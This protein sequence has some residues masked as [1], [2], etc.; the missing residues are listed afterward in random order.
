MMRWALAASLALSTALPAGA[1]PAPQ[2]GVAWLQR[3]ASAAREVNYQGTFVYQHGDHVETSRIIHL[4]DATGE[5]EKLEALD[6][7]PREIIRSNDTVQCYLPAD[8]TLKVDRRKPRQS[9]PALL[10]EQLQSLQ[11]FYRIR[12]A[13]TERIAG[14]ET[15]V[16]ALE[17][18]DGMRY[19]HKLWIE[20]DH[21]LLLK[22]AM[23]DDKQRVVEQIAFTQVEIGQPIDRALLKPRFEARVAEWSR[24]EGGEASPGSAAGD[25]SGWQVKEQPP[26][27]RKILETRRN[28]PGKPNPVTH[29]MLSDGMA[30]VSVFIEPIGSQHPPVQRL[31]TQGAINIYARQ[32]DA[33]LVTVVGE[34]PAATVMKIG[35]SVAP[36][37]K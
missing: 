35:N 8:K 34:A 11:E 16:L 2:D 15:Q 19:G 36:R 13:G 32:V 3:T 20:K 26:G 17:P 10:P 1:Q 33:H 23:L 37:G 28:L 6:G 5:H 9:F 24:S 30:A 27:F 31:S 4:V 18:A 29:I 7:P 12:M 22:R 21:G 14:H 25:T